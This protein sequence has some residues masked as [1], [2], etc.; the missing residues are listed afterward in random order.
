MTKAQ[1]EQELGARLG[2]SIVHSSTTSVKKSTS[3][4]VNKPDLAIERIVRDNILKL[5]DRELSLARQ[6]SKALM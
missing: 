2:K 1:V 6:T 4:T 5:K 3:Y